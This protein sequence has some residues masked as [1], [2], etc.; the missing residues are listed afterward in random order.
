[1]SACMCKQHTIA[2]RELFSGC[3]A[4]GWRFWGEL[5]MSMLDQDTSTMRMRLDATPIELRK[6]EIEPQS[7]ARGIMVGA[8]LGVAAWAAIIAL[9][10]AVWR[11][12]G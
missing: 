9:G 5:I 10:L 6:P 1:M 12:F 8:L 4:K 11:S 3:D 2:A 7:K